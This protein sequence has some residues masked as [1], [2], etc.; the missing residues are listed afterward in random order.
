MREEISEFPLARLFKYLPW[1]SYTVVE[2][3]QQNGFTFKTDHFICLVDVPI[4]ILHAQD[5]HV[6]PYRLG[7]KLYQ[8]ALKCRQDTQGKIIFHK[9]EGKHNYD[10]RFICRA[11]EIHDIISDFISTAIKESKK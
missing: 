7:Y 11:P 4:I 6:V 9:F 3:M 1:F 10:H 5:D 8:H 2:P